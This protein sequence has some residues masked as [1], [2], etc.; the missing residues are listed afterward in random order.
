MSV[1]AEWVFPDGLLKPIKGRGFRNAKQVRNYCKNNP[2][3]G[4]I[5]VT[6]QASET[7]PLR[8]FKFPSNEPANH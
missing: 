8:L 1:K 4:A 6:F 3:P 2:L 5:G 7:E